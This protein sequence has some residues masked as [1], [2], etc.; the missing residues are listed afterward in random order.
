MRDV[1][2]PPGHVGGHGPRRL[3][4]LTRR[5]GAR[6]HT[7]RNTNQGKPRSAAEQD[8]GAENDRTDGWG[9]GR[10]RRATGSE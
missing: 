6:G 10:G 3:G 9:Q 1:D 8:H 7:E 5:P 2:R 4:P